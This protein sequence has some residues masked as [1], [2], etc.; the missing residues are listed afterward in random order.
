M[1]TALAIR[2]DGSS[3][4]IR[5]DGTEVGHADTDRKLLHLIPKLFLDKTGLATVKL[6]AILVFL[7]L[8]TPT[9]GYALAN[10]AR[11]AGIVPIRTAPG[12]EDAAR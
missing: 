7:L 5:A 6:A 3:V 9:A 12:K 10:A 8:T 2:P 1:E 11:L 4:L